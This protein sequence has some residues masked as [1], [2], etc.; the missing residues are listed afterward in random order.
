MFHDS[1]LGI[2]KRVMVI[3]LLR[4]SLSSVGRHGILG[5]STLGAQRH[6]EHSSKVLE[7]VIRCWVEG[8][9]PLHFNAVKV[10]I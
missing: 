10:N 2:L 5:G 4:E 1:D 3:V 7:D 8:Y 9:G 6:S